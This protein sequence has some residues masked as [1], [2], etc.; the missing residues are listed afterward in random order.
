LWLLGLLVAGSV[1]TGCARPS[2]PSSANGYGG[3]PSWLPKSTL[4]VGRIVVATTAHPVLAIEGDTVAVNLP[5]GHVLV[6]AVGPAVPEEG[7][8]PVPPTS[9]CT[10]T[11]TFSRGAG[12][13]P[14]DSS[15]FTILDEQSVLHHPRITVAAG[16]LPQNVGSQAV[17]VAVTATLP[18]GNGQ[19]RWAPD[20]A[21]PIVSWD[22]DVEID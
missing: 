14:L 7:Q 22:F 16:A 1:L 11:V 15:S 17:T 18:T 6:T 12:A 20:G 10:F 19:L 8:F 2:P 13:V 21:I 4:P 9:P 3:L 5:A